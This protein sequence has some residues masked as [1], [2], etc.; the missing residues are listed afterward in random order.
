MEPR[1][2]GSCAFDMRRPSVSPAFPALL[3]ALGALSCAGPVAPMAENLLENGSFEAGRKP[4]FDFQDP[5]KPFWGSFEIS[6]ELAFEGRHSMLLALDSNDFQRARNGVG[7]AGGA[8]DVAPKAFPR[9]L[10]GRYRVE[11]W[12]RG[13]RNQY[14]QLVVM[15]FLP[16]NFPE[17]GRLAIQMAFVLTGVTEPPFEISNRYFAFVG[18][19]QPE[20]KRWIHFDIDLHDAFRTHWG[21]VP[22]GSQGLRVFAEAR[23]DGYRG[24]RDGHALADVYFDALHLGD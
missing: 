2:T 23:F 7:I 24:G 11:S 12:Q 18:P 8:Q 15:A 9:R 4:W 17:M 13:T 6:D 20:Q 5:K 19:Y 10:S 3:L 22:E 14:V 1:A 16:T 21:R